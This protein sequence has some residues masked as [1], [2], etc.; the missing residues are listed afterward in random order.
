[1]KKF[2]PRLTVS[3]NTSVLETTLL[4]LPFYKEIKNASLVSLSVIESTQ[5]ADKV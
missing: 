5:K 4:F 1:M 3:A 2:P